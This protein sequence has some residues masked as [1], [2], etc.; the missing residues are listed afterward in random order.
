VVESTVAK[1]QAQQEAM[2]SDIAEMKHALA[3]I[4]ESMR[5]ISG[6]EQRQVSLAEA[7]GR[8]HSRIDEIQG[9]LKEEVKGHE[10]RIQAI[11]INL[12]KNQWIERV[13]MAVLMGAIGLWIKGGL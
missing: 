1:L 12:A 11:E 3:S 2:G 8:A 9:V 6:L 7:I 10:K 13:I 5:N 4:A